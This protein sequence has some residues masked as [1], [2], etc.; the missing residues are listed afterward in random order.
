MDTINIFRK[1]Q[2]YK[3]LLPLVMASDTLGLYTLVPKTLSKITG[4]PLLNLVMLYIFMVEAGGDPKISLG[5]AIAILMLH[6]YEK[7]QESKK[8]DILSLTKS[9]ITSSN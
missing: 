1:S 8:N 2:I 6:L 3:I 9:L 7:S 5:I 4:I